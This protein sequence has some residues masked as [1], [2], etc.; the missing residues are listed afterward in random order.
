MPTCTLR[1]LISLP[2]TYQLLEYQT[3]MQRCRFDTLGKRTPAHLAGNPNACGLWVVV[4]KNYLGNPQIDGLLFIKGLPLACLQQVCTAAP[5]GGATCK[6]PLRRIN[7]ASFKG[8]EPNMHILHYSR[9]IT[10]SYIAFMR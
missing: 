8:L 3:D 1:L 7:R 5:T 6:H 10:T 2:C 9:C 4:V